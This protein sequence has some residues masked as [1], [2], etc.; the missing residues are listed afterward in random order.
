MVG[1]CSAQGCRQP[2]RRL[3][4]CC[5]RLAYEDGETLA[6]LAHAAAIC[7]SEWLSV[8]SSG[9]S[10]IAAV[11]TTASLALGLVAFAGI[12]R[13]CEPISQSR[14]LFLLGIH[15]VLVC[16]CVLWLA[17][18]SRS[19][20]GY[21]DVLGISTLFSLCCISALHVCRRSADGRIV[22]PERKPGPSAALRAVLPSDGEGPGD[23]EQI[24]VGPVLLG[25]VSPAPKAD[26]PF[27][28]AAPGPSPAM[29]HDFPVL[30]RQSPVVRYDTEAEAE[31]VCP[32]NSTIPEGEDEML[33]PL[34]TPV[35]GARQLMQ[36]TLP[37]RLSISTGSSNAACLGSSSS[38]P[39]LKTDAPF[40]VRKISIAIPCLPEVPSSG[41]EHPPQQAES[42]VAAATSLLPCLTLAGMAA[43]PEATNIGPEAQIPVEEP[44]SGERNATETEA[45]KPAGHQQEDLKEEVA[46]PIGEHRLKDAV[47]ANIRRRRV[48]LGDPVGAERLEEILEALAED[49]SMDSSTRRP[50]DE[51]ESLVDSFVPGAEDDDV[52]PALAN[53]AVEQMSLSEFQAMR[54]EVMMAQMGL[55]KLIPSLQPLSQAGSQRQS[56]RGSVCP[57]GAMQPSRR[58]SRANSLNPSLGPTRN[59]SRRPSMKVGRS[60]ADMLLPVAQQSG[61]ATGDG[62]KASS[63]APQSLLDVPA[64]RQMSTGD[65]E[66]AFADAPVQP[67]FSVAWGLEMPPAIPEVTDCTSNLDDSEAPSVALQSVCADADDKDSVTTER[68]MP[69]AKVA[70]DVAVLK[71]AF[72]QAAR[73]TTLAELVD[74][75]SL[76]QCC[77]QSLVRA[78]VETFEGGASKGTSSRGAP[79][80]PKSRAAASGEAEGFLLSTLDP[81][82]SESGSSGFS[83]L[84]ADEEN[85]VY[86]AVNGNVLEG[87][88]LDPATVSKVMRMLLMLNSDLRDRQGCSCPPQGPHSCMSPVA[89]ILASQIQSLQHSLAQSMNQSMVGTRRASTELL[90]APLRRSSKEHKRKSL[91]SAAVSCGGSLLGFT[92]LVPESS[93]LSLLDDCGSGRAAKSPKTRD[94]FSTSPVPKDCDAA[95]AGAGPCAVISSPPC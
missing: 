19:Q 15:G 4:T 27:S 86:E 73:S 85:D 74:M 5:L 93:S 40:P 31:I 23:F 90:Q 20:K 42:G 14:E 35:E 49:S 58:G 76:G 18:R 41:S 79:P 9:L 11:V 51:Q 69:P 17:L 52:Q 94:D 39:T 30:D 62:S 46:K 36:A 29:G 37:D 66:E 68:A 87:L 82:E 12:R 7:L 95:D 53:V 22:P 24:M 13:C 89:S 64:V 21:E 67:A 54:E 77:V 60:M 32:L 50:V 57:T 91:E 6:A 2:M 33:A 47:L 70:E 26:S 43:V 59:P 10:S 45:V 75:W 78:A 71:D 88:T 81:A 48:M 84:E 83:E 44:C 56:R 3:R 92:P 28:S 34:C 61:G 38:R 80:A 8:A 55:P 72:T 25:R 63:A 16:N 1:G 65:A